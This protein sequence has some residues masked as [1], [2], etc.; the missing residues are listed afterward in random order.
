MTEDQKLDLILDV[1]E[2]LQNLVYSLKMAA[3]NYIGSDIA[4]KDTL[5]NMN[6]E[7]D[8][9]LVKKHVEDLEYLFIG[10]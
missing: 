1:V 10:I 2:D 9:S 7:T 6:A 8:L 3:D 4:I 5:E